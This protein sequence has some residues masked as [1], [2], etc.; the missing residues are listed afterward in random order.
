M[1]HTPS[2]WKKE[3]NIIGGWNIQ[4]DMGKHY[5]RIGEIY[6]RDDANLTIAAPEMYEALKEVEWK[7]SETG[8]AMYCLW[9]KQPPIAGHDDDCIRQV[10]L[11]KAGG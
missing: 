2:P 3:Q 7:T 4:K 11:K 6:N 8:E 10:A 9:C 1:A 5:H